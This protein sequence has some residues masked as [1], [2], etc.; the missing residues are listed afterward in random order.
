MKSCGFNIDG[1][2]EEDD[3]GDEDED[4]QDT[5]HEVIG[6]AIYQLLALLCECMICDN[7]GQLFCC[8]TCP[9]TYHLECFDPPLKPSLMF[10]SAN[11]GASIFGSRGEISNK[12]KLG[13]SPP[14]L[15]PCKA[16]A[17]ISLAFD[18]NKNASGC[19][20]GKVDPCIIFS[21][22]VSHFMN[23]KSSYSLRL[24]EYKPWV[25][26][27]SIP[28][29]MSMSPDTN[30]KQSSSSLD[31]ISTFDLLCS[32]MLLIIRIGG[33]K[34]TIQMAAGDKASQM[35]ES[36]VPGKQKSSDGHD[37]SSVDIDI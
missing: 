18:G 20:A 17:I 14:S 31:Q 4:L 30:H 32:H 24:R 34:T 16:H 35:F 11:H 13:T 21:S 6:S 27:H 15:L 36:S 25:L 23:D 28:V 19:F 7:G 3:N 1:A 26:N 22:S 12:C 2:T 10:G 37:L 8:E 5:I 9:G 29:S 33:S